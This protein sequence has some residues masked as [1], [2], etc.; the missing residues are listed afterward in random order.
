MAD[1]S[2]R[3]ALLLYRDT[4]IRTLAVDSPL[5]TAL[6]TDLVGASANGRVFGLRR[7]APADPSASRRRDTLALLSWQPARTDT[8]ARFRATEMQTVASGTPPNQA[9]RTST[10]IMASPEQAIVFATGDVAV[11]RQD[12]YRVD[13]HFA[14]G[15]VRRGQPIELSAPR[16]DEAEKLSWKRRYE[17]WAG[18]ALPFELDRFPW[19]EFVPP[20]RQGALTALPDG[21]LAIAREPWSGSADGM[22]DIVDRNGARIGTLRLTPGSRIVGTGR[23]VVYVVSRNDDGIERLS[24]HAWL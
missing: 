6:G 12:P 19:A 4:I 11:A 21:M 10:A 17:E 9:L 22:H 7:L 5:L 23:G 18:R 3:R 1:A 20:F 15:R 2:N 13:W 24:R 14:D 8:V 16:I